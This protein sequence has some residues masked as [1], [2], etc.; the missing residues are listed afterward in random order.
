MIW[1]SCYWQDT[2]LELI[3]EIDTWEMNK[4]LDEPELAEI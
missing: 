1:E 3:K 2:L 4:N